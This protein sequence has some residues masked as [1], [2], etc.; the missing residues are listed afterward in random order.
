MNF[1]ED[2]TRILFFTGKGGVG[3]TSIACATAVKLADSGKKVL[4]VSTDPASN[5]DEVLGIALGNQPTQ[6]P[7][8]P[9]LSAMN[10]NP[11]KSA[12]EYR[13]RMVGPYRG[14]LP[15]AA[16]KS[17]EEQ[18]SGACTLEIAAFDEFSR[19]LADPTAT[20]IF[21]HVLFDT[22]PTGH[23][24]RLLTLPS[25]W[26]G[27]M[28]HNTTGASCLGPLAGL[29]AQKKLY[30][31]SVK[32]L[33]DK[34]LTTL[35]LVARAE[36]SA[37]REAARTSEELALL[38]IQNQH[39]VINGVFQ[40]DDGNDP[41]A[42]A[43]QQRGMDAL[44]DIPQSLSNLSRTIVPLRAKGILG[45][46]SLRDLLSAESIPQS[47][48]KIEAIES[49]TNL[50]NLSDLIDHLAAP[51]HGVILAMGKG[52]VGKTTIA[53]AVAV[54]L[55]QRGYKVHLS[56]TDPAAHLTETLN[57]ERLPNLSVKKSRRNAR[58]SRKG[59]TRRRSAVS[60]YRRDRRI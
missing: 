59:T 35:V 55:A 46:D 16:V 60:L 28:E 54:A 23:T 49:I 47:D 38:G 51:G 3:K 31:E 32:T 6:I 26:D 11:E 18:F 42:V 39:L 20:A 33:S 4:L 17:M 10:L 29:V 57:D 50:S 34:G 37:L 52:G 2:P 44:R 12:A 24:L 30:Q 22:A 40:A 27:Y 13:E 7:L 15:D 48:L 45:M 58:C 14:L 5:L 21:D 9:T 19:L 1:L 53:A 43:L 36:P 8:L 25:A 56:T 41:Y